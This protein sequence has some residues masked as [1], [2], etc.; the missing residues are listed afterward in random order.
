MEM[1]NNSNNGTN[2]YNTYNYLNEISGGFTEGETSPSR[3]NGFFNHIINIL[4]LK[5]ENNRLD[6]G[7]LSFEMDNVIIIGIIFFLLTDNSTDILLIIC[8][9]LSLLNVDLNPFT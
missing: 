2:N 9:G 3:K 1:Y 4:T 5:P 6:I 7:G 8:L